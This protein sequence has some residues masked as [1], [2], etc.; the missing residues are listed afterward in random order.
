MNIEIK[1]LDELIESRK[2]KI[3][4]YTID[5]NDIPI[6]ITLEIMALTKNVDSINEQLILEN[7]VIPIIKH[8]YKE[9]SIDE[10]KD[11]LS[12]K[13]VITLWNEIINS[14]YNINSNDDTEVKK[15]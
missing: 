11:S 10:I 6:I 9:K 14:L 5:I 3:S 12:Y 2:V 4:N 1:N 15:K 7:V 13:Q 8:S